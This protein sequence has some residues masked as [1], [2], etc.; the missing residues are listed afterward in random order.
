MTSTDKASLIDED[1]PLGLT[2]SLSSAQ[3]KLLAKQER[4]RRRL[5]KVFSSSPLYRARAEKDPTYWDTFSVG[6]VR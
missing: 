6:I 2:K 4:V 5:V 1:D 3:L